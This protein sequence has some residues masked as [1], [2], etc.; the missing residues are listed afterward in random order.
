M[1]FELTPGIEVVRNERGEVVHL[2][3]LQQPYLGE[4]Q[5]QEDP[6][7]LAA[8]YLRDVA[9]I[10]KLDRRLLR[11]LE[12]PPAQRLTGEETR[13]HQTEVKSV[14]ETRVIAY[15][16]THFD[17][18]IWEAGFSVTI[19][20]NPLRVVSSVSTVHLDV[21]VDRPNPDARFM[22]ERLDEEALSEALGLDDR[23]RRSLKI[24]GTS[25][26]IYRFD[27]EQRHH[28]ESR[29]KDTRQGS[30]AQPTLDL[31]KVPD[32][33]RPGRHYVVSEVL[34][35]LPLEKIS[36]LNWRAFVE[37][38]TGAVLYLRA[39]IS[40]V[41][42]LTY[43]TDP[44]TKTGDA[45]MSP[46]STDAALNPLRINVTIPGL[47]AP[48]PGAEQALT[49]N[50]V[51]L[52]DFESPTEAAPTSPL[53]GTFDYNVRTNNFGAVG[54][55]YHTDFLFRLVEGMGFTIS[56]PAGFWDGTTFPIRVDHRAIDDEVNAYC[57]Y[58]ATG[59]G[60][61]RFAYGRAALGQ[62]ISVTTE[63][64]VVMH[65]FGHALLEDAIHSPNFGFAH[66]PGDSLAAILSD[67]GSL[68]P[69]R[70]LTF[71]WS[72][73]WDEDGNARRHDRP[74][75]SGWAWD[76]IHDNNAY[77]SEQI[78]ST[79][80]FR[81][82]QMIGGDSHHPVASVRLSTQRFAARY[83]AYLLVRAILSLATSPVT[84][85]PNAGVLASALMA[86]D[87]GTT[88]FEGTRGGTY[89]KV[90][91]W[92]FEKQGFYQLTIPITPVTAPGAPPAV[93]VYINDGRNGEYAPFLDNFWETT[94][95]WNLHAANPATTPADH[96]EPLLAV[97]NF[98]YVKVRNRG[99][100]TANNVFV[101]TF[102]NRPSTSL[103]WPGDWEATTTPELPGPGMPSVS[104]PT[105]G[106]HIF[107]PFEWTPTV[108]GHE[109]LL[110]YVS[111]TDDRSNIDPA[112][113]FPCAGGPTPHWQMV[114]FDNNI[115]QRNVAPVPGGRGAPGL[116]SA[117]KRRSFYVD[118][119]L[120]KA[121]RVQIEIE[122]PPF[123]VERRWQ[124]SV[125]KANQRFSL[126]PGASRKVIIR[127]EPGL[128]FSPKD[129]EQARG[130]NLIRVRT[131]VDGI[132][133][134]GIS[135]IIDPRLKE[136]VQQNKRRTR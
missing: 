97:P 69:D 78:L 18:P 24:N 70:G 22:P 55:Y 25:L 81:F 42:G 29:M 43:E 30:L 95:I 44:L 21:E 49:G 32:E 128:D 110:A 2:Q 62:L 28:P 17:L 116:L 91:R 92:S 76:G 136:P 86:A 79:T 134:G 123:L 31:P 133:T 53:P 125:A 124:A 90:A 64:R 16:E 117:F 11:Q 3:H 41:T 112:T 36:D 120:E 65:E 85:T 56:G 40:F 94:D 20:S 10:Y 126:K 45:T 48:A 52:E 60:V 105:G 87:T 1:A 27:P 51:R 74:V 54:S 68:A 46:A 114:P 89:H 93:D 6:G 4:K 100:Q 50:F 38:E 104:I 5:G 77:K 35:T 135:Y 59:T 130:D 82:Y 83:S 26:R 47:T 122:L 101:R 73:F 99:T 67:P 37:V 23:A 113:F 121:V 15:A 103:V 75:G 14:M 102:H 9:D 39:F 109:C 106:E 84:P 71:P 129:V 33:I 108:E 72:L 13:L 8:E 115:A 80:L 57:M 19:L 34:F 66:S 118:N 88:N 98:M 107:G 61:D 96:V 127:L 119:Q 58:N 7:T 63:P 111:A 131:V 12:A 132:V